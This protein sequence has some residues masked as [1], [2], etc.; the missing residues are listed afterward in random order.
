MFLTDFNRI[1]VVRWKFPT[2]FPSEIVCGLCQKFQTDIFRRKFPK[3]LSDGISVTKI[4][5]LITDG[6]L[7]LKF[8][9]GHFRW[10]FRRKSPM[11][12]F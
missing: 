3:I 2:Q 11:D 9:T 8:P 4:P 10:H 5:W 1:F 6:Y 7:S 12:N